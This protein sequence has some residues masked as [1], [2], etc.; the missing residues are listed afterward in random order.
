[1]LAFQVAGNLPPAETIVFLNLSA[2]K[3]GFS[4]KRE[5]YFYI[6]S[7]SLAG[8]EPLQISFFSPIVPLMIQQDIL[9]MHY[10]VLHQGNHNEEWNHFDVH[11]A[12][13]SKSYW[14]VSFPVQSCS[15][16]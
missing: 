5:K 4:C 7:N 3:F 8:R 6:E 1:M 13:N 9:L 16:W 12:S 11:F 2:Q 10:F 15:R 14:S